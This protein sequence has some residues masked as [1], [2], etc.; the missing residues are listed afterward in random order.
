[1]AMKPRVARI[2]GRIQVCIATGVVPASL[3]AFL[4]SIPFGWNT[5]AIVGLSTLGCGAGVSALG[6]PVFGLVVSWAW[7][8]RFS[9]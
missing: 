3:I 7:P 6:M 8:E 1:M 9:D 4:V 5:A 2:C